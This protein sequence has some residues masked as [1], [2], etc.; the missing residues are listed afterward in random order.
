[1]IIGTNLAHLSWIEFTPPG[2]GPVK[3]EALSGDFTDWIGKG[4]ERNAWPDG[5]EFMRDLLATQARSQENAPPLGTQATA[6]LSDDD[7][8]TAASLFLAATG[9]YFRPKYI[10]GGEG[11]RRKI[12]KR[13]D[14]EAYDMAA[15]EGETEADRLLR[16]IS[17]WTQDRSDFNTMIH[18]RAGLATH[19]LLRAK[20]E[21]LGI[22][23]IFEQ[24]RQLAALANP[25]PDL[26][27]AVRSL[28]SPAYDRISEIAAAS[29]AMIEPFESLT[30]LSSAGVFAEIQAQRARIGDL[31]AFKLPTALE[32]LAQRQVY[33][34][35]GAS[36]IS[37]LKTE[38]DLFASTRALTDGLGKASALRSLGLDVLADQMKFASAISRQFDVRLPATTLAAIGALQG[39]V[40]AAEAARQ[41]SMFPPGFQMAAALG[42]EARA[43]RGLVAD[44][45]H[46][47]GEE[48]P[49]A[50]VF[51]GVLDSTAIFDDEALTSGEAV[52][53]LQRVA[54]ALLALIQN[55][56]D[57][58]VRGGMTN[59]LIM[60]C[61]L[62][63]GYVGLRALEVSEQ[64]LE[65]ARQAETRAAAAPANPAHDDLALI[66]KESQ[67]TRT[68]FEAERRD[69][70]NTRERIRY[71]HDRTPLRAEPKGQGLLIRHV[72]PDQLLRVI[73]E[74]GEWLKVEVFDYQNDA[75][76]RGWISRQRVRANPAP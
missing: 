47:Y 28:R 23:K 60:I 6:L 63:S 75:T 17:A 24:Q 43:G 65:V 32:T 49:Q 2:L 66:L 12:R 39:A 68:A 11:H 16:I 22:S 18:D 13:G 35:I 15:T 4:L 61:T 25:Y 1:M 9:V 70:A 57:I 7:L 45:L 67:A 21:V 62:I 52:S 76:T 71:V 8:D 34:N 69:R 54:G 50:P 14:A 41:A 20:A 5:R 55:E 3:V 38:S 46:R 72:Y 56:R 27:A 19:D 44:V 29:K 51:A 73:D 64:S 37:M 31:A 48:T 53:F 42:L 36:L 74:Q 59:V 40:G 58:L 33:P 26:T 10:A 30:R